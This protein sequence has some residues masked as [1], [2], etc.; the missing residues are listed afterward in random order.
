MLTEFS[1]IDS[2]TCDYFP[3]CSGCENQ[4]HVSL[5]PIYREINSFFN[6]EVP[7][8]TGDLIH[9]RTRAKLAVRRDRGIQMGL[10]KKNSHE[11]VS[12]PRCPLHHPSIE[13][14]YVLLVDRMQAFGI[15]PYCET[16]GKGLLRYVQ[17]T[18]ERR[19]GA[20]QLVLVANSKNFP[21]EFCK[22]LFRSSLFS[23]IWV[24]TQTEK[25]NRIFGDA[26]ECVISSSEF[27]WEK[28]GRVEIP[29]HPAC[30]I[31]AHLPM[32]EK[33]L[34][35]IRKT[36]LPKKKVVEFYGG[37]GAIALNVADLSSQVICSEINPHAQACFEK[38]LAK[39][40]IERAQ[41][42][43]G[44]SEDLEFLLSEAEVLIVDPPRKGLER[45]F[46]D[47]MIATG[48]IQQIIYVSCYFPSFK[49]DCEL[50]MK[51][52]WKVR[53]AEAYLFF[54][55]TNHLETLCIFSKF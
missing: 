8:F 20:I 51:A 41:F 37:V 42:V 13:K 47:A 38:A 18:V 54:P 35:S 22:E 36:I 5:P 1:T 11:V 45:G 15:E 49:R 19:T 4:Q 14:G 7:L 40:K 44:K 34:K 6:K 10:F 26:W 2:I 16:S 48:V 24:N 25:T 52:G 29:F 39:N 27:I 23:S 50:L 30:F 21:L 28:I 31:Q 9:W 33:M 43:L 12:I 55:G 32:F 46:L 17:W 3:A 53:L